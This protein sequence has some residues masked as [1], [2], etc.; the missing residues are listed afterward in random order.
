MSTRNRIQQK[1]DNFIPALQGQGRKRKG[2]MPPPKENLKVQKLKQNLNDNI[3]H[4]EADTDNNISNVVN[5]N[6]RMLNYLIQNITTYDKR[7]VEVES[8]VAQNRTHLSSMHYRL[9]VLEQEKLNTKMEISG[10]DSADIPHQQLKASLLE[11]LNSSGIAVQET[12]IVNVYRSVRKTHAGS[13]D[14]II[15][16]FNSIETK[17]RVIKDKIARDKKFGKPNVYFADVLTPTNRKLFMQARQLKKNGYITSAWTMGGNVFIAFE[18]EGRKI[19]VVNDDHLNELISEEST[20]NRKNTNNVIINSQGD[21]SSSMPASSQLQYSRQSA[22]H[23]SSRGNKPIQG[24][25]GRKSRFP[26][27][28][29][30]PVYQQSIPDGKNMARIRSNN[31]VVNSIDNGVMSADSAYNDEGSSYNGKNSPRGDQHI[32]IEG[33]EDEQTYNEGNNQGL[34]NSLLIVNNQSTTLTQPKLLL[35]KQLAASG[36]PTIEEIN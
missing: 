19:R 31:T 8:D 26:L 36:K 6:N 34:N 17:K 33:S 9:N 30:F 29:Q 27:N 20:C 21:S 24:P 11:F 22:A 12:E 16:N 2:D 28:S 13:V 18:P 7:F 23:Q 14:L 4:R 3:D 32:M 25:N 10:I 15:A 5:E 1:I 35:P